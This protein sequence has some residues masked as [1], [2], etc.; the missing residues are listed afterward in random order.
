MAKNSPAFQFYPSDFL[1]GTALMSAEA[2]G[3]YIRLLCYQWSHG[4]LPNDKSKLAVLASVLLKQIDDNWVDLSEKFCV[5]DDGLLRNKRMETVKSIQ[6][7]LSK[8]RSLAGKKGG[9]KGGDLL[10]Q[11]ASKGRVKSE[12]R[13]LKKVDEEEN[14]VLPDG[15]DTESVRNAL[16]GW[17]EMRKRIRKPIRSK[18]STSKIFKRFDGPEHLALAAEECEANEW[19]GLKPEY[20]RNPRTNG[21]QMS[22][23]AMRTLETDF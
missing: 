11:K 9:K 2:V 6:S 19:Q 15:W 12:D 18:A 3:I 20:G 8:K 10:K 7:E 5:C 17:A 16:D 22:V 13:S 21:R 23:G 1:I 14:W 4:G